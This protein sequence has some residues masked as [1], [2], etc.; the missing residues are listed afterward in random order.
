MPQSL[1]D[2]HIH[3]SSH[4]RLGELELY[5]RELGAQ[6]ICLLS[7]P[8]K[9]RINF[10]PE[11]LFAKA[12]MGSTCHGLA[13]FDYSPLFSG[14]SGAEPGGTGNPEPA[15]LDL[16]GQVEKFRELGFDGLKIFL[17]KPSF[18][19]QLG[20]RLDDPQLIE[21]FKRAES[22]E[23]PVLI[24][25]ADPLIFWSYESVPGFIPPGWE[26][27]LAEGGGGIPAYEDL[28]TQALE[29][30][31]ACP[32]LTVIF[33]HLLS[34]GQDIPR[35]AGILE[36][37]PGAYLD[38]APGLYFYHELDRQREAA[39]EF[40]TRFRQRILFGTDAFWFPRW[41]TEFPYA[42]VQ[43]NLNRARHLLGFLE[44]EEIFDNPFVPTKRIQKQVRGLGL[45]AEVM[46]RICVTN[47]MELYPIAPRRVQPEAC[48][49]YLDEFLDRLRAV[50]ADARILQ[51][52]AELKRSLTDLFEGRKQ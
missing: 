48:R 36:T 29:V 31:R 50:T 18:Q 10:N 32:D 34:M 4:E 9:Q 2:S 19:S 37:Y 16:P 13:S 20:L 40:F 23:M 47:F 27:A 7:L 8:L 17:G 51:P 43:D 3:F 39:R 42:S 45:D 49:G 11:V 15:A 21:T 26:Q 1:T 12:H 28:Q 24:H 44:T 6:K 22:L 41:F 38:L 25:V 33:P 35:L 5:C 46:S 14:I 30:L 52:V